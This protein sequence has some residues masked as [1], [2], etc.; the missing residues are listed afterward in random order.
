[1]MPDQAN[2]DVPSSTPLIKIENIYFKCEYKNPTGSHKDRAFA[3]QIARLKEKG[4][5]KAV[6]SSSGNAAISASYYCA[7]NG[8]DLT[9][10]VSPQININKLKVLKSSKCEI[11]TN[12]KP[13]SSAFKFAKEN[14]VYNL[15]QSTDPQASIGHESIAEEILGGGVVPD[16]VFLPVSSGTTL[17][18]VS[19]GFEK[20]G[21]KIPIHAVQTDVIYPVACQFDKD[22][23]PS[24]EKSLADAIVARFTP[25]EKDLIGII[26][27]SKG[28]GW[29]VTNAE[30]IKARNWLL[31]NHLDCSYEGA[32]V[33]SALWKAGKKGY[34]FG[35]PVC[36]LT[37]KYY[38]S[39]DSE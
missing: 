24:R 23:V 14:S 19:K 15:R 29:V 9:V 6:I 1:M 12:P 36:L 13:I 16:A 2:I 7:I 33:L 21:H 8:I 30:M 10:F 4:I 25:R 22:F 26:K 27:E 38:S 18:G 17:V 34:R 32:A 37:G 28:S 31:K 20:K 39:S 5:R 3:V 11:I 35:N